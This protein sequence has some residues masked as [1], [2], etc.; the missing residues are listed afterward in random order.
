MTRPVCPAMREGKGQGPLSTSRLHPHIRPM[1]EGNLCRNCEASLVGPYCHQC[2]Q[3]HSEGVVST[4]AYMRD[5]AQR[6]ST[7][8]TVAAP[9]ASQG[10]SVA[11]AQDPPPAPTVQV[12]VKRQRR[13]ARNR[14]PE[15]GSST[16]PDNG[17]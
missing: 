17:P 12:D 9:A 3:K 11:G 5:V 6:V 2:G 16:V 4:T 7:L 10:A 15:A 14:V 8:T 1:D 13:R